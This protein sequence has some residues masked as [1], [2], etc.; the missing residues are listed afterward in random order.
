MNMMGMVG[1][2]ILKTN[3]AMYG[4]KRAIKFTTP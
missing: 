4:E 3:A 1:T 2:A